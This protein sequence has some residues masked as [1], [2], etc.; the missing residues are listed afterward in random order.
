MA[1][2]THDEPT[3]TEPMQVW[4]N[5]YEE[6]RTAGMRQDEA[7]L[8]AN[9]HSLDVGLLRKLVADDCPPA[10]ISRIVL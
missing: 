5:R 10:L 8:F 1:T 2:T 6:A 3:L 4:W 7:R 9:D